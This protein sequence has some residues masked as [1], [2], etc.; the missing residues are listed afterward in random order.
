MLLLPPRH[1]KNM[2]YTERQIEKHIQMQGFW[3]TSSAEIAYY[4]WVAVFLASFYTSFVS[5]I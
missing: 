4:F 5:T 3:V 1:I 2:S